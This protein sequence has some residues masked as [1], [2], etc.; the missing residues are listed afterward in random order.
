MGENKEELQC[1]G[2][3]KHRRVRMDTYGRDPCQFELSL[4][5]RVEHLC[6]R[7]NNGIRYPR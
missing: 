2:S 4:Q 1:A 3:I 5:N 7:R 6:K